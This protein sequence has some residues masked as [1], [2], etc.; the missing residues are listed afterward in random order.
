MSV[1]PGKG[2]QA[3][4]PN[5]IENLKKVKRIKDNINHDLIIQLDGGVTIDIIKETAQ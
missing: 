3:F 2:G 1:E 4:N 5:A